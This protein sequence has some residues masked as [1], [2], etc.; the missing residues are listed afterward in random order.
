MPFTFAHAAAAWPFRRTRLVLSA[1]VTGSFAPDFEYFLRLAPGGKL[2]HTLRGAFLFTL[3][4][5]FVAYWIYQRIV[6]G[7]L[8]SL[9]PGSVQSRLTEEDIPPYCFVAAIFC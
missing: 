6:K 7:A 2:G 1:V 3:P 4:L 5:A 9:L 8:I